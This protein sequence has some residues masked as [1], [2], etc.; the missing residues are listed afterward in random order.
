MSHSLADASN[1]TSSKS[2]LPPLHG[3]NFRDLLTYLVSCVCTSL[4]HPA[5]FVDLLSSAPTE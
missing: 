5:T 3:S 1:W 4:L 2:K